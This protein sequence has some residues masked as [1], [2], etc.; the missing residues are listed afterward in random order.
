MTLAE[1]MIR[2]SWAQTDG[3]AR[4]AERAPE[5]AQPPAGS[6]RSTSFRSATIA[7][8]ILVNNPADESVAYRPLLH[9]EW[10]GWTPTDLI[11]PFF[12]F[13]VR[14][15]MAFSFAS[16][17]GHGASRAQLVKHVLKRGLIIFALGM[18]LNGFPN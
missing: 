17:T 13:V 15:A 2:R 5:F 12:L 9:A 7:A 3:S 6:S 1:T 11:F 10:N 8:M 16:R 14:V 4:P 18:F